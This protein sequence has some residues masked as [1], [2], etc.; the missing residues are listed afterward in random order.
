MSMTLLETL[1][2]VAERKSALD[3]DKKLLTDAAAEI[4]RLTRQLAE[5]RGERDR[6]IEDR[7]RFPDRPDDIGRMIEAHIGNLRA[8]KD[9]ADEH[10]IDAFN[11]LHTVSRQLAEARAAMS[12]AIALLADTDLL[13]EDRVA[14]AQMRLDLALNSNAAAMGMG[15]KP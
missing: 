12:D 11:R 3:R 5:A 4:D 15:E 6:L 2:F 14:N 7:A 9:A 8:G 10:A 1:R 13:S